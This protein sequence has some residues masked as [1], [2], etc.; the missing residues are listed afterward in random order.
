MM[1]HVIIIM[2]MIVSIWS[3]RLQNFEKKLLVNNQ[4]SSTH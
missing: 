4:T 2:I 3:I 1:M